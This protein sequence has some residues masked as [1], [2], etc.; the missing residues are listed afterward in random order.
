MAS[1]CAMVKINSFFSQSHGAMIE[2]G[3]DLPLL[4]QEGWMIAL[5]HG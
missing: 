3:S 2:V 1:E 5:G 4:E